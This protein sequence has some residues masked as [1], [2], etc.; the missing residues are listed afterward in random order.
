MIKQTRGALT[1]L[2]S[3]YR[4]VLKNAYLKNFAAVALAASVGVASADNVTTGYAT[5]AKDAKDVAVTAEVNAITADTADVVAYAKK[6][7]VTG[8]SETKLTITGASEYSATLNA[9]NVEINNSLYKKV[10]DE[11]SANYN[12]DFVAATFYQFHP[13]VAISQFAVEMIT[14][15]YQLSRIYA[16]QMVSE[17]VVKETDLPSELDILPDLVQRMLLELKFAIVNERIDSMQALLTE[18]QKNDDWVLI[19]AI[20][21]QQPQLM[22]IRQVLCKALGNRVILK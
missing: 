13:D 14:D 3:V 21:E 11:F 22:N 2:L 8:E 19:R 12:E 16:Q 5:D 1:M 10:L 4:S 18:A 9:D 6:V 7:I 15:K 17:N 20:L